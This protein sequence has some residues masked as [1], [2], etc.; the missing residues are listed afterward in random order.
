MFTIFGSQLVRQAKLSCDSTPRGTKTA[1]NSGAQLDD[2]PQSGGDVD[3]D[4][5]FRK[6]RTAVRS[7]HYTH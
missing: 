1:D 4:D 7:R 6:A 5:G 3:S 2:R